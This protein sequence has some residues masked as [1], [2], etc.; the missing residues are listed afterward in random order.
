MDFAQ[1]KHDGRTIGETI[2]ETLTILEETGGNNAFALIK[3]I[4]PT[5]ETCHGIGSD[6]NPGDSV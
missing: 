1:S 4:V 2:E 6:H 5:Y 3:Y